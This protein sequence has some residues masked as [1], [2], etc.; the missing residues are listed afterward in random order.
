MRAVKSRDNLR[1][2]IRMAA[3]LRSAGLAGWRRQARLVG[4]PDF[5]WRELK[6]ALFVDGCFWHGCS[7]CYSLPKT[8]SDYWER[9]LLANRRRDRRV[10]TCLRRIGWRVL[11]VRQCQIGTVRTMRRV[12][13]M[14][15]SARYVR[16]GVVDVGVLRRG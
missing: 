10:N 12:K 11:R 3:M 14:V 9:K 2:E 5:S 7:G 4:T 15:A 6:V 1:T 13:R 8:N 16:V